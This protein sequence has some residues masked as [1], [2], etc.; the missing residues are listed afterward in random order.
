MPAA[1]SCRPTPKSA[2]A[3]LQPRMARIIEALCAAA[4][5]QI[6][7]RPAVASSAGRGKLA[8]FCDFAKYHENFRDMLADKRD[9]ETIK[10]L[11]I[12]RHDEV[13]YE[14]EDRLMPWVGEWFETIAQGIKGHDPV[15]SQLRE[16][17]FPVVIRYGNV[18]RAA[19]LEANV[20]EGGYMSHDED[21][22]AFEDWK[23]LWTSSR[24]TKEANKCIKL[25]QALEKQI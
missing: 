2:L 22:R 14:R 15:C 5:L 21:Q 11:Y 6:H 18:T 10:L 4:A 8:P 20:P 23:W 7:V 24:G 3:Q 12:S 25:Y 1:R 19:L 16:A 17:C 9:V 13:G